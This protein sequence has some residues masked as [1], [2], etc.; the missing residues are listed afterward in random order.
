MLLKEIA[1]GE[2]DIRG[3]FPPT[4]YHQENP[5]SPDPSEDQ[6][7]RDLNLSEQ[8]KAVISAKP[9]LWTN[10]EKEVRRATD[11]GN[12]I[13]GTNVG[14]ALKIGTNPSC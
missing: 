11:F 2:Y 12:H 8:K 9:Q 13:C 14:R 6:A 1:T 5:F 10:V 3:Y 4:E 7:A